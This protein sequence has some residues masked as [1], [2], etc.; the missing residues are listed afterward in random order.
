MLGVIVWAELIL[1]RGGILSGAM[2]LTAV[3]LGRASPLLAGRGRG[4][5]GCLVVEFANGVCGS[6]R[7][8][9]C[10]LS[11]FWPAMTGDRTYS[12]LALSG[13]IVTTDES[14]SLAAVLSC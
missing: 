7:T 2:N 10:G 8:A 6:W 5:G 13:T 14:S 3:G 1:R 9:T 12:R 4:V 11:W